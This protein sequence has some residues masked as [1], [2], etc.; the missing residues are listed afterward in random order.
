M[1]QYGKAA[2]DREARE[3]AVRTYR[4]IL[5]RRDNPKGIYNKLVPHSRPMKSFTMPMILC[6]VAM[7]MEDLLGAEEVDRLLDECIHELMDVHLDAATGLIY[8]HVAPDGTHPDTFDGRLILPGHAIEGMWFLMDA[9]RRRG[10][11]DL[12]ARAADIVLN[13]LEFAWDNRHGG[14]FY[15]MDA[16]GRPPQ[17]LEWDQ[18]LWWVHLEAL[19]A[20]AMGYA[21]T[22]RPELLDWYEKVHDYTW[23]RFADPEH[24]E[25]FGYLNRR[26]EVLLDLKGG[27]WKGCFH[28]PRALY[29]C[30]REFEA[31][32]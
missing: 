7:E 6:N 29:R 32:S 18:K 21:D 16:N 23:P 4:N 13:M 3:L 22:R 1:S 5:R 14:I 2:D 26:G 11:K 20:L 15:F 25:W 27:K 19:V 24:G 8:E 31:L 17:Q 9:A 28:V 12:T 30:L 10:D